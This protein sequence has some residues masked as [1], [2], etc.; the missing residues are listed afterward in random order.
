MRKIHVPVLLSEVLHYLNMQSGDSFIDCTFGAGG[1]AGEVLKIVGTKGKILGLDRDSEILR[2]TEASW[3]KKNNVYIVNELFSKLQEVVEK[4]GFGLAD[5][6]LFDLGLSSWQ[7]DQAKKGFSFAKN[8]ILDMRMGKS[9]QSAAEYLNSV[10]KQEL[11]DILYKY[12]EIKNSGKIARKIVEKSRKKMIENTAD[13]LEI[14]AEINISRNTARNLLARIWQ[15]I[16]MKVNDEERELQAALQ[17]AIDVLKPGGR[18]AVISFHSGEDR[19][20]K[21]FFKKS[22]R[23]C[24][25]PDDFPQCV[26]EIKPSLKIIT[27][28]AI[29]PTKKEISI[30]SRSSSA[31]LRVAMKI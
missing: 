29:K 9:E 15:A 28:K 12:G 31:K 14:L 2:Q 5:A 17:Q 7:L 27:K 13:L 1:H 21:D 25:C 23:Q 24:V 22:S 30:N 20:V 3:R 19:I 8:E 16:R 11:A 26:C 10:S 4:Q 6:V 18:L